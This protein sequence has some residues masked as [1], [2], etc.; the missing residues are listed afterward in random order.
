M[1]LDVS[2]LRDLER[3]LEKGARKVSK[4]APLVVAKSAFD[5]EASAK[6]YAPVDTGDLESSV[7]ATPDGLVAEIGPTVEYGEYVERGT[8]NKDGTPRTPA[9]PYMEPALEDNEPG[10]V[11]GIGK[12]GGS[13]L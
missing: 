13:I 9:Q 4:A 12:V 11:N 2:E 6:I 3:D 7:G 1:H 10:F 5:I 8:T